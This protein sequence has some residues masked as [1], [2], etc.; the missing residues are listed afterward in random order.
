[1]GVIFYQ[2]LTGMFM[3]SVDRTTRR[4]DA[5]SALY[6]RIKE[7]TWSWPSNIEIGLSTFDFLNQTMQH[8]P[9]NRP[10]W[11]EMRNHQLFTSG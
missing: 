4:Q 5:M 9:V 2:M 10:A 11:T 8:D 6:E 1:M 7:G 3:F